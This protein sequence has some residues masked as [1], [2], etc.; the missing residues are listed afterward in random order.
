MKSHLALLGIAAALATGCGA[1]APTPV[2]D[3]YAVKY[4]ELHGFP[5]RGLVLGA[6]SAARVDLAMMVWVLRGQGR[7]ILVDAGFHR[8]E[9]I[10]SWSPVAYSRPS[11]ALAPLGI[12][13]EDVTD[14][15]VTHL[16]W[17]HADGIDL[18][19]RAR[20]WVQQD[21]YDHYRDPA[22]LLRT[23]V[24]ASTIA[25][26]EAVAA[27]GRL[28]L[29]AGDSVEPAPGVLVYT[30]GRHT[31]ESQY[32]SVQTASGTAVIASDNLYLYHNLDQRRPIAAT[33]DTVSNLAAHERMRRLAG[34]PRLIVPGHDPAVFDR[35]TPVVP[36]I[37]RIE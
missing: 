34:A 17:D 1:A 16:H 5:L 31:R 12:A 36:G 37:V 2:Y 8:D 26:L 19:P 27:E 21:E 20:V 4:A 15:I 10:S 3:V 29:A 23:G 7:V 24:F 14:L 6:D 22:N 30:G 25:V 9:F 18:F 35:F 13:P 32:V 33:W 11:E 28:R